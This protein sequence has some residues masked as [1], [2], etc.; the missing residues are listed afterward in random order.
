FL[1]VR[2]GSERGQVGALSA[3]EL[4]CRRA[5]GGELYRDRLFSWSCLPRHARRSCPLVQPGDARRVRRDRRRHVAVASPA[6][7]PPAKGSTGR[8]RG[9]PAALIA[10]LCEDFDLASDGDPECLSGAPG[11]DRDLDQPIRIDVPERV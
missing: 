2:A 7:T 11:V 8:R 3:L 9:A 1:V 4:R 5:V 10:L 6:T